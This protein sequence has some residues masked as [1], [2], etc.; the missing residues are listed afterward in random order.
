MHFS[1][2]GRRPPVTV[3]WGIALARTHILMVAIVLCYRVDALL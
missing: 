2:F 1:V 3:A